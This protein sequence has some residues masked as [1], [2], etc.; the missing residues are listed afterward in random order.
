M[1]RYES[2]E[3]EISGGIKEGCVRDKDAWIIKKAEYN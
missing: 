3:D 2:I 1:K